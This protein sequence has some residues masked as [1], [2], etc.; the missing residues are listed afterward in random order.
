MI[1][2]SPTELRNEQKKYL[3]MAEK[4][5]VVIKRGSK[6]IY[7]HVKERTITEEDLQRGITPEELLAGVKTHLRELFKQKENENSNFAGSPALSK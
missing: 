2:I 7:L 1:V 3:D 5:E 4:E 6:L